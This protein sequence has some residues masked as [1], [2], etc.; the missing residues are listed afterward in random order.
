MTKPSPCW[1]ITGASGFIGRRLC[2]SLSQDGVR[3]IGLSR[4]SP[5]ILQRRYAYFGQ[6]VRWINELTE[7]DPA[8][9]T[10]THVVNLNG[11]GIADSRWTEARK[12]EIWRSR[13]DFTQTLSAWI[14]GL[15]QSPS[16]LISGSAIGYYGT[17]FAARTESDEG[18][19]GFSA[20]LCQTWEKAM[21]AKAARTV[22]LRIGVVLGQGGMLQKLQ[23]IYQLGMGGTI[24][25]GD[26]MLSWIQR[27]DLVRLIR[28]LAKQDN[29][30]V[31]PLNATAP[32]PM[33][34]RR[35]AQH[36]AGALKRPAVIP[37]PAFSMRL[38]YGEMAE[39]LLLS[40]QTVLPKKALEA[41]FTFAYP[42]MCKALGAS[43]QPEEQAWWPHALDQE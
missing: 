38:M 10:I 27:D 30:L 23:P 16:L 41:G 6:H 19:H 25:S 8:Q 22:F 15:D 11:A 3:F 42:W 35:F 12:A 20:D 18:G 13:V 33:N 36:F 4:Q 9:D 17:G 39:E 7:I 24:G 29:T 5:A 43:L 26:Q 14:N 31:G 34:Q 40:G 21:T 32:N 37:T 28:W 1:L 2:H